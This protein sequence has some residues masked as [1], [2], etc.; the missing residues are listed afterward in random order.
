MTR[1]LRKIAD[2]I[3]R[4]GRGEVPDEYLKIKNAYELN[5]VISGVNSMIDSLK[6]VMN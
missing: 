6:K 1:S 5:D 4:I 2:Y 3:K